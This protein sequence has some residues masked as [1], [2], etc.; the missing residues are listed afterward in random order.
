MTLYIGVLSI[1]KSDAILC[2]TSVEGI[3]SHHLIF[4]LVYRVDLRDSNRVEHVTVILIVKNIPQVVVILR[5]F[6]WHSVT[7]LARGEDRVSSD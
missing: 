3:E 1:S 7:R 5:Y 6:V 4:W 2:Y